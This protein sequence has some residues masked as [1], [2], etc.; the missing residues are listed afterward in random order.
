MAAYKVIPTAKKYLG[1]KWLLHGRSQA[2]LDCLG[3]LTVVLKDLHHPAYD[4]VSKY[5]MYPEISLGT[6]IPD[7]LSKFFKSVP[8]SNRRTGDVL[9]LKPRRHISHIGLFEMLERPMMIH[10]DNNRGV[11]YHGLGYWESKITNVFR[12]YENI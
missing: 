8:I 12:L 7:N 3:L 1:T 4:G 10:V 5:M 2:G 11:T 9:V 6:Y